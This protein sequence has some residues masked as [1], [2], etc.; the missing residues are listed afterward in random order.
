MLSD[1]KANKIFLIILVILLSIVFSFV[2]G[3][4]R[5]GTENRST[6][7]LAFQASDSLKI[8]TITNDI[9]I[10]VDPNA[11]QISFSV[12]GNERDVLH[13][14]K[15][16]NLVTVEVKPVEHWFL[17][18]V[19]YTPAPLV[20]TL[21]VDTVDFLEAASVSGD[22]R[23]I[24]ALKAN[25]VELK[26]T[27]GGL[28]ILSLEAKDQ[29]KLASVSGGIDASSITAARSVELATTSGTIEVQQIQTKDAVL[30]S[31]S[32]SIQTQAN[33]SSQGSLKASSTS[34]TLDLDLRKTKDL[35]IT[36][37]TLSG[38]IRFNGQSQEQ[39]KTNVQEGDASH[40][41][42]MNTVS[43]TISLLY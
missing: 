9:V 12:G 13:V 23:V 35:D 41:V 38:D 43:G 26:S 39:K 18:F 15:K 2:K 31:I 6:Q 14:D 36:A 1:T 11:K 10:E 37:S 7:N 17:H 8:S 25:R 32:G 29:V 27:S 33:L 16:G 40:T 28:D 5:R 24:P 19:S 3:W 34:G 4:E 30:K 21:P 20:V 42:Q 22:I